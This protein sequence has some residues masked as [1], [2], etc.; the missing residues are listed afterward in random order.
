MFADPQS[1]TINAVANSLPR[2][3]AGVESGVFMKDDGNVTLTVR[4]TRANKRIRTVARLDNRKIAADPLVT[5]NNQEYSHAVYFVIDRPTSGFS[6][7]ETK[8]IADALV[9]WLAASS[10]ANVTKLLGVES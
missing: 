3:Q 10:G 5:G 1:V 7:T 8:Y 2:I 6:N 4:H 9:A